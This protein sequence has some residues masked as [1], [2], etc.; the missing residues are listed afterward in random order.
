MALSK[1]VCA[2]QK[3][4]YFGYKLHGVCSVTA[5]FHSLDIAKAEVHDIHFLKN[6][7]QQM[8]DCVLFVDTGCKSNSIQ[9]D[10][11]QTV[12]IKFDPSL[13]GD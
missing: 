2:S 3:S 1:V 9:L 8:S 7:K 10:L 4:R 5:V 11:L 6:I 13:K 12:N